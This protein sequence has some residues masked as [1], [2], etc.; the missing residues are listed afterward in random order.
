[1]LHVHQNWSVHVQGGALLAKEKS[2]KIRKVAKPVSINL[3]NEPDPR[4]LDQ[5]AQQFVKSPKAVG[6]SRLK[7]NLA[8]V[9]QIVIEKVEAL[10]AYGLQFPKEHDAYDLIDFFDQRR[11][12]VS[13]RSGSA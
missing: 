12:V 5:I 7:R 3:L 2:P 11:P 6:D 4:R 10:L 9:V 8:A 13:N 1:M